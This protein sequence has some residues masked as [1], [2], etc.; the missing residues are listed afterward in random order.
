MDSSNSFDINRNNY[1]D[2]ICGDDDKM[3]LDYALGYLA[4]VG[5]FFVN[6]KNGQIRPYYKIITIKDDKKDYIKRVLDFLKKEHDIKYNKKEM[7]GSCYFSISGSNLRN[8]I[9]LMCK[10]GYYVPEQAVKINQFYNIREKQLNL[11]KWVR[12]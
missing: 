9:S 10:N 12:K 3:N 11:S 5:C 1:N 4:N 2:Y 7:S 8:F 6:E